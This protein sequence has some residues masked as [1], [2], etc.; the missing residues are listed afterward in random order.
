MIASTILTRLEDHQARATAMMDAAAR[1]LEANRAEDAPEM[2][3]A[4][5]GMMRLLT[6]YQMF[7]HR[8]IFDPAIRSGSP[9]AQRAAREM[10]AQCIAV[11]EEFRAYVAKWA[12]TG[13]A[14]NWAEYRTAAMAMIARIREHIASERG[15]VL[16][17]L[18]AEPGNAPHV[19]GAIG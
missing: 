18:T 2:G 17:I 9:E 7:K 15:Q 12:S 19:R 10:K 3:R 14:D 11:G 5:W 6:E 1:I 4:R 8:E 13:V 16:A